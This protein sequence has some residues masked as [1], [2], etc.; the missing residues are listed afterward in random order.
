MPREIHELRDLDDDELLHRKAEAKAEIFNLRFQLAT[1]KQ[2]N[3]A[4]LGR[5]RR[6]IARIDTLLRSREI[7]AAEAL[8]A[9]N[10]VKS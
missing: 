2:N 3:S 10:E 5:S 6:T 9:S 1:G 7:D 8:A 4:Q